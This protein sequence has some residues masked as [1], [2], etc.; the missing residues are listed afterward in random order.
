MLAFEALTAV[1]FFILLLVAIGRDRSH[2]GLAA[3]SLMV[4][5]VLSALVLPITVRQWLGHLYLAAGYWIPAL[6]ADGPP[7]ARFEAWL[8]HS[9]ARYRSLIASIPAPVVTIGDLAYLL[10][11]PLVPL[12]FLVVWS[13]G[14][15]ADVDRYWVALLLAGFVCYGTLPWLVSRPPRLIEPRSAR[16]RPLARGNAWVLSRVSHG[17]NTFPSGHV[18]VSVAAAVVVAP[19]SPFAGAILAM[20]AAGIALGAVAGRYHFAID[21]MIGV[22][23]GLAAAFIA[24]LL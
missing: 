19:V 2:A 16:P 8:I 15:D 24:T 22:A 1:Y 17:R 23:A 14:A 9:E 5:V 10:C 20:T 11:Y 3:L 18:A 12:S 7:S 6:I 4:T 13:A 21:V